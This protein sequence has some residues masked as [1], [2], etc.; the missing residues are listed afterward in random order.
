MRRC[1]RWQRRGDHVALLA[2]AGESLDAARAEAE[3]R[4]G[5]ALA[6]PTDVAD[7]DA[8]EQAAAT[9]EDALGP[10]DVWINSRW[11]PC[12][13]PP[14]STRRRSSDGS[15]TVTYL[16][17]VYGTLAALRRM[18]P[19][20]RGVIVQVG[21]ALAYRAIPLQAGYCGAKHALRGF[22]DAAALRAPA[23]GHRGCGSRPC[24]CPRSTRRSS[25]RCATALPHRPRPVA[26]VY[27][28]EVAARAILWASDHP[29]RELLVG[30]STLLAI[31]ASK[32]GASLADRYL[33]RTAFAG[34]QTDEPDDP[35]RPDN[36]DAPLAGDRGAH[37]R[38]GDEARGASVQ[39]WLT[40]H[41]RA[42]GGAALA[43][44][45]A[46]AWRVRR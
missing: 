37:G 20:D 21:S 30:H 5:R 16:G 25:T 32:V 29:R 22:T 40:T 7:A 42:L 15:P 41:R 19:R 35:Q 33:A 2:R 46:G 9:V 8:V 14:G 39:L 34:Q 31:L 1:A 12:S 18:R 4:G 10:I 43:A 6:V 13:R 11:R 38:F 45:A 44:A 17:A 27:R 23:R 26:P 3:T 24:T 36:L 28:P